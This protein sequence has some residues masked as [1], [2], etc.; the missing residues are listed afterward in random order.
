[1]VAADLTCCPSLC[2]EKL[3]SQ[4][5]DTVVPCSAASVLVA[6]AASI[7]CADELLK[8]LK[9]LNTRSVPRIGPA[10]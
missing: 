6:P 10:A 5:V 4:L 8:L 3:A 1:M 9:E 2:S 7:H